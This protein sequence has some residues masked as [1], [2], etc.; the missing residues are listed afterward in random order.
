MQKISFP[1]DLVN[2]ILQYLDTRPHREVRPIIDAIQKEA[3][4]QIKAEQAA[5]S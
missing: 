3:N 5:D 1:V 2:A 4:E